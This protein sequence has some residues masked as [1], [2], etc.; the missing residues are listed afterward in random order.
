MFQCECLISSLSRDRG[1]FD[2]SWFVAANLI[3]ELGG[4]PE[5][6]GEAEG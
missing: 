3:F 6:A 1:R 2:C 5:R 4:V